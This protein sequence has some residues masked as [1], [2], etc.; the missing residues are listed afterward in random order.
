MFGV[1]HQVR[2]DLKEARLCFELAVQL[3]DAR[4]LSHINL[5]E[6]AWRKDGD[7]EAARDHLDRAV[8]A[9]PT[10]GGRAALTLRQIERAPESGR[11]PRLPTP[12]RKR[13]CK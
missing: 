13:K 7:R 8:R 6:L 3:D 9:E 1:I 4:G 11:D 12:Q 5:G 2:G 10:L